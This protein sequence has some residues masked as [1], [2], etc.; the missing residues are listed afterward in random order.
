M[1]FLDV[2]DPF[3]ARSGTTGFVDPTGSGAAFHHLVVGRRV[4]VG[5]G[6]GT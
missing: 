5:V 6:G 1:S 2:A 4:R 3:A